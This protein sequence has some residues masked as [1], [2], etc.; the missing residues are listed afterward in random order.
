MKQLFLLVVLVATNLYGNIGY[1]SGELGSVTGI[2]MDQEFKEPIPYATISVKNEA[3]EI[4]TGTVSA[5]DGT[6]VL[7]KLP[8]G[9]YMF[10]IQFMGYESYS[11]EVI[12]SDK[13]KDFHMG[14]I[15]LEPAVDQL[16]NVEV[17]AE[18]STIEQRIDRKV[19]NVGKD[20]TT[21]GASASEIM[22]NIPS[23]T[24]D[25]DGNISMRGNDNVRILVDGKPTNIPAAQLLKQIP[26]T[27]IKSIELITNPSAKYNPE[28]MSGIIN[29]ILHKNS[30][31]GFNGNLNT[32]VTIGDHTR[33]NGSLNMNYRTGKLNFFGN[34]GTN[35]GKREQMGKIE[36]FTRNY[37]ELIR[38]V[39][40]SESYLFKVGVDFYLD[41]KNTFSVYTNQNFYD[42]EPS[43]DADILFDSST[44]NIYQDFFLQNE[45]ATS[46][47]NF[48]YKRD[49]EKEG[50]NLIMEADHSITDDSEKARFIYTGEGAG[51]YTS[52]SDDVNDD[53]TNTTLNLDY[54]NPLSEKSKLELGA[55]ARF[56]RS[57]NDYRTTHTVLE[58]ALYDYDNNIYSFYSTFGQNFDK[59]SYQFGAR[60]EHYDV[61]A[62]LNDNQIYETDYLTLYPSAFVSYKF[63]E[64]KTL[65]MSYGR[66]VDRPGLNQVNPVR[67][68][69]TPRITGVGN[70]E[71]DPQ[72][73]NSIELNYTQNFEKGSFTGGIF[74]RLIEQEISQILI[75]DPEDPS[76]MLLTYMNWE[77][78][79]AYGLELSGRYKP[80]NWW[81]INPSFE[82]YQSTEKG[83]V[84]EE[85]QEVESSAWNFRLTQS[86]NVTKKL[87]LQMFGLYRSSTDMLQIS[88]EEFYFINAGARYNFL[89]DK[90]TLSINFNDIFNTQKFTFTSE[91]PYSQRGTFQGDSQNVYLGFSY[92]FGGGKNGALKRKDRDDNEKDGGGMF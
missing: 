60:F 91:I 86:W 32:G 25:Q 5:V 50:H 71:L 89:K 90:A 39:N 49:F 61:E 70:P 64:M 21:A 35:G 79:T 41:D 76:R 14:E 11:T 45:N 20:L 59:W 88:P 78:N 81:S 77:D 52:Y 10:Q 12:I 82:L 83:M 74:Y 57:T 29:I 68:F 44:G 40:D 66:R 54:E 26:S 48:V 65:Q 23:L 36:N 9:T 87:T 7:D 75:I 58:D 85:Y 38:F 2:V 53:I 56:R 28:G 24:V 84:G 34:L 15:F 19:I 6:F 63:N 37:T 72:F 51:D 17:V 16:E 3:G 62:V 55:E 1:S 42:G 46:T 8:E 67:E 73:T 92:R 30:N 18:R 13:K 69:S 33:Y 4:V 27:S 31:L 43:G 47:Y 22:G 80:F